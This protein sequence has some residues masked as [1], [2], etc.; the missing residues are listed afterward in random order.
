M[1][2]LD[3]MKEYLS[4]HKYMGFIDPL[5]DIR[6]DLVGFR[7]DNGV[8][9]L[10]SFTEMNRN[11]PLVTYRRTTNKSIPSILDDIKS[12][13]QMDIYDYEKIKQRKINQEID[14]K[15]EDMINV[16]VD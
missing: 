11:I 15:L 13:A 8:I 9:D 4:T 2:V 16:E 14:D 5:D 12:T 3:D 10:V 7:P 6:I 1:E